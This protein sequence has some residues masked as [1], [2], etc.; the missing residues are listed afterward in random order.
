MHTTPGN[1]NTPAIAAVRRFTGTIIP[2]PEPMVFTNTNA[3]PPKRLQ[4]NNF[5]SFRRG[6][7]NIL[8]KKYTANIPKA[9]AK[10][11]PASVLKSIMTSCH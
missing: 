9:Y 4:A 1:P 11:M 7:N 8:P 10:K 5:N 3:T 2:I 6:S